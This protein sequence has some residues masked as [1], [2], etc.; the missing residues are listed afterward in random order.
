MEV[1]GELGRPT[2]AELCLEAG[3]IESCPRSPSARPA[4]NEEQVIFNTSNLPVQF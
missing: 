4:R 1:G 2:S 3:G